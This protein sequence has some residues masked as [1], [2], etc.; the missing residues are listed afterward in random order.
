[1]SSV[2]DA[3]TRNAGGRVDSEFVV[4]TAQVLQEGMPAITT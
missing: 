4:A 2:N 3:A 1:V